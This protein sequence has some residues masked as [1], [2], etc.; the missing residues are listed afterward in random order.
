GC[1]RH[2]NSFI[3]CQFCQRMFQVQQNS[4]GV[5]IKDYLCAYE[6]D[7]LIPDPLHS[8][9]VPPKNQWA[10]IK[11]S[12][13]FSAWQY[14]ELPGLRKKLSEIPSLRA[15]QSTTKCAL[16]QLPF[17]RTPSAHLALPAGANGFT[18]AP[19]AGIAHCTRSMLHSPL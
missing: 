8:K 15:H 5:W 12:G 3:L 9:E 1:T 10:G 6:K 13:I 19:G 18:E 17:A 7:H 11:N 4:S 2:A 16:S 14:S